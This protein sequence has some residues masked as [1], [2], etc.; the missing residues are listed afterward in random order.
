M[1]RKTRFAVFA[2]VLAAS[3]WVFYEL[4]NVGHR[5]FDLKIYMSALDWWTSG[6]DLY[7]Y[8]QPDFLQGHLYFTYP[9]FAAVLMLPFSFLPLVATEVLLTIG[10]VAATIVTTLWL[11]RALKLDTKW[12][13]IAVP[14]ILVIEPL[15]ETIPLGQ[16]NM[17]L[18]LLVLLD[19]LILGPRGSR[20]MGVGIGLATAIKLLPGIFIVYLLLTRQWRAAFTAMATAAGVT[21]LTAAVAPRASWDFWTGALWDTT[22]VGRTDVTGNQSLLGLLHRLV[23]PEP[24]NRVIWLILIVAVLAFGLWRAVLAHRRGDEVAALAITGLVGGLVV[25]ITWPHHLYWFVPAFLAAIAAR[26]WW[27]AIAGYAVAVFGVVSVIDYGVAVQ[28]TDTVLEFLSRNAFT[29]LSLF[30]IVF[31]PIRHYPTTP[32]D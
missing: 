20:W 5:F 11:F 13:L 2:L 16:I 30:L 28:P 27:L 29:L 15:R 4:Y 17:L 31:M 22:R 25:P 9:P 7:D 23:A 18:V 32:P 10:T 21:L 6:H 12:A 3:S 1:Q 19:L 8:A 14:L 24:P 26:A